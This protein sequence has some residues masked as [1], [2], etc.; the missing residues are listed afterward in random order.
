M[1]D[2]EKEMQEL[3]LLT[4]KKSALELHAEKHDIIK[5]TLKKH[6]Y[7]YIRQIGHGAF[8]TVHLVVSTKYQQQ[9]S[10]KVIDNSK[11]DQLDNEVPHMMILTHPNVIRIYEYFCDDKFCYVVLEYCS[12]GDLLSYIKKNG[13]LPQNYLFEICSQLIGALKNCH[14]H[15]ISHGDIKPSNILIDQF[16]RAKLSDFGLSQLIKDSDMTTVFC[17]S[18]V[19]MA[20]EIF[21]RQEYNPFLAD[22]WSLGVTFYHIATG[23]PPWESSSDASLELAISLCCF[24]PQ[25]LEIYG[26]EFQSTIKQMLQ[27]Q[28]RKRP[29][30]EQLLKKPIFCK[31]P[32]SNIYQINS[33]PS[34][35]NLLHRS[36]CCQSTNHFR[37]NANRR[38]SNISPKVFLSST[39]I[40]FQALQM[41]KRKSAGAQIVSPSA[42]HGISTFSDLLG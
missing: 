41:Q 21:R 5:E 12:N 25:P 17:G 40:N 9:F 13:L 31:S 3:V 35:R 8:S 18:R 20:P 22:I 32:Q 4:D 39:S 6:G 14:D 33:N 37:L 10:V 27:V 11:K 24:S 38:Q 42:F 30:L 15:K 23:T 1:S 7:E 34:T 19:Y 2:I 26:K 29:T 36:N 28:P 16:G